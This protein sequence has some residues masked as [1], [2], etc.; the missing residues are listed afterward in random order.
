MAMLPWLEQYLQGQLQNA[1]SMEMDPALQQRGLDIQAALEASRGSLASLDPAAQADL[2]AMRRNALSQFQQ[3]A[4]QSEADFARTMFG[5][6]MDASS[7]M[8]NLGS[9]L[10]TNQALVRNQI[11]SDAAQRSLG[12]RQFMSEQNLANLGQQAG[13][14]A[15]DQGAALNLMGLQQEG[16]L[17]QINAASGLAA[18][19]EQAM[20]SLQAAQAQAAATRYSADQS[21]I[22]QL[23]AAQTYASADRYGADQSL[24]AALASA[25][26]QRYGYDMGFRGDRLQFRLGNRQLRQ[27]ANQFGR[28]LD[29]RYYNADQQAQ[30]TREGYANNLELARMNQPST[31]DRL[32]GL[33]SSFVG[34]GG[35]QGL[36]KMFGWGAFSDERLKVEIAR[37]S[38]AVEKVSRLRPVTWRWF[39]A[40]GPFGGGVIAQDVEKIL[41]T[42]V[43]SAAGYKTV[44]Y[45]AIIGLLVGAVQELA[46]RVHELEEEEE[47]VSV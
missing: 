2:A 11:E 10:L 35:V 18:Q 20:R 33:A 46:T 25:A 31:S 42:A 38:D 26:A 37:V 13:L 30:L 28:D 32:W 44:D 6:G 15:Q 19:Y 1:P 23:G 29:Y 41:P 39:D 36:G 43:E 22:A 21:R 16:Y 9:E 45:H 12:L 8:G 4:G 27:D 40:E 3:S 17:G 24:R 5:R 14:Y 47:L 7:V 34:G